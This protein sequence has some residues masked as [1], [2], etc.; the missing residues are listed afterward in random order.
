MTE[1]SLVVVWY[2]Y[3]SE[4]LWLSC[5]ATIAVH[6]SSCS[7]PSDTRGIHSTIDDLLMLINLLKSARSLKS[8]P[9]KSTILQN[10]KNSTRQ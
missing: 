2:M 9:A 1:R 6:R 5:F 7:K 4:V 8:I 3:L 10:R